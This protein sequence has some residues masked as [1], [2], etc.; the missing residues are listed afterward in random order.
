LDAGLSYYKN[1]Y[2]L[3]YYIF[4]R[5]MPSDAV[6]KQKKIGLSSSALSQFKKYYPLGNL[7]F[8]NIGIL[9]I[10]LL[11]LM[12]NILLISLKLNFTPTTSGFIKI[13]L[14][15]YVINSLRQNFCGQF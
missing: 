11:I 1:D 12:E 6:R 10:K 9:H 14:L 13:L 7:K 8:N 15:R 4:S 2:L 3:N 5:L